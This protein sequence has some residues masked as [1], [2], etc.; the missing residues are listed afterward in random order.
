M[1]KTGRV[2]LNIMDAA[3]NVKFI[4][5]RKAVA[6]EGA[7]SNMVIIDEEFAKLQDGVIFSPT[8]PSEQ[9]TGDIWNEEL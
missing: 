5:W 6:G 8:E 4:D 2:K 9:Q 7:D 3:T 1:Q